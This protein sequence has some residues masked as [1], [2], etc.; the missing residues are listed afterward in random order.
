MSAPP[1]GSSNYGK[2]NVNGNEN[3]NE[4]DNEAGWMKIFQIID[5]F[6]PRN[7]KPSLFFGLFFEWYGEPVKVIETMTVDDLMFTIQRYLKDSILRYLEL[8]RT[9]LNRTKYFRSE[10]KRLEKL[11]NPVLKDGSSDVESE[12]L[13]ITQVCKCLLNAMQPHERAIRKK[14]ADFF[15]ASEFGGDPEF[16]EEGKYKPGKPGYMPWADPANYMCDR[17][18]NMTEKQQPP[19]SIEEIWDELAQYE[20]ET[21]WENIQMIYLLSKVL[22]NLPA[23][24]WEVVLNIVRQLI[25]AIRM[26][27]NINLQ[28]KV[29]EVMSAAIEALNG[30]EKDLIIDLLQDTFLAFSIR[31]ESMFMTFKGK[32]PKLLLS[33]IDKKLAVID[34]EMSIDSLIEA[35]RYNL[36]VFRDYLA[37]VRVNTIKRENIPQPLTQLS[38]K[39]IVRVDKDK[40]KE[41]GTRR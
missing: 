22:T 5:E 27:P 11:L 13:A 4:G 26:D 37:D 14:Q 9:L 16:D 19:Q 35:N 36:E 10:H 32:L 40:L 17:Q 28:V 24:G 25:V 18:P 21:H 3:E 23:H 12:T 15:I 38:Y 39:K 29:T 6:D 31:L 1:S 30:T 41:S 7:P 8:L 33:L 34:K 2:G 20:V